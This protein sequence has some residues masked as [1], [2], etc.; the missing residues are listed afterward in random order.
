MEQFFLSYA[1]ADQEFA[2][3]LAADLRFAG[4]LVWVDQFDIVPSEH[5]DRAVEAAVRDSKG[6]LLILSPHAVASENVLD[7]VTVAIQSGKR[8]VPVLYQKCELPLRL[9]RVQFIDATGDYAVALERCKAALLGTVLPERGRPE[10]SEIA[11]V[12]EET[13]A[14]LH[15]EIIGKAEQHLTPHVG[16]IASHLV[17][18]AALN[19]NN[20]AELYAQLSA[21]IPNARE[22]EAFLKRTG[23]AE[24]V[25]KAAPVVAPKAPDRPSVGDFNPTFIDQVVGVL[26]SYI[27]PIARH[28]VVRDQRFA[29]DRESLY[30]TLAAHVPHDRERNELLRKLRAL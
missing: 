11:P 22:R 23:Q 3:R 15:P 17:R 4:T 30:Q 5:W 24:R 18:K 21:S 2:L 6:L 29:I 27:G 16:P 1:R 14:E 19:S 26:V 20:E 7:E 10:A 25:E 12:P 8:I 13:H 9:S 28:I